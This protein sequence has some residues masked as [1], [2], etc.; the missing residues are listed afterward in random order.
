[1]TAGSPASIAPTADPPTTGVTIAFTFPLGRYH[2]TATGTAANDGVV[3]WPPSPWR[4]LR[5]LYSVWKTRCDDLDGP[6][7]EGLLARLA[8]PPRFHVDVRTAGGHTR[9]YMPGESSGAVKPIL[10]LDT[11]VVCASDRPTLFANWPDATLT[12]AERDALDRLCASITW[13]GRAESLADARLLAPGEAA[14]RPNSY[15]VPIE[16]ASAKD[17]PIRLLVPTLPLDLASLTARPADLRA[18]ARTRTTT[19]PGTSL[20]TFIRPTPDRSRPPRSAPRKRAQPTA[21]RF[22]LVPTAEGR[23]P[24]RLPIAD[25]VIH[26]AALRIA[27]QAKFGQLPGES[28]SSTLSG[29]SGDSILEGHQH[30]H[31]LAIPGDGFASPAD[32]VAEFVVWAPCGFEPKELK[33]LRSIRYVSG[34]HWLSTSR[35][36]GLIADAVADPTT[37]IPRLCASSR[38]WTTVTPVV[39]GR[40]PKGERSWA[41]QVVAEITAECSNH[42]LPAPTIE[43]TP[44]GG[45]RFTTVRPRKRAAAHRAHPRP[46]EVSLTFEHAI[47]AGQ[48]MCLGA[49]SHFGLGLFRPESAHPA[50]P[51]S[52]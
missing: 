6:L 25:A 48:F 19:P 10:A 40:H 13:L 35:P 36:F 30:A 15:L 12:T 51:A 2:A 11:F 23:S 16:A 8:T 9:H 42:G 45:G 29:R 39:P 38:R 14:P 1:M 5:A 52:P 3:E 34:F 20:R 7:V 28:T 33:A 18:D 31:Y 43:L 4:L 46:F 17:D 47:D 27:A 24:A 26:T 41:D 22:S 44:W 50:E 32:R 37:V 21:V 49:M